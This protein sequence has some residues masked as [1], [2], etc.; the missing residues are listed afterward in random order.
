MDEEEENDPAR[1]DALSRFSLADLGSIPG[2]TECKYAVV[3]VV[4]G[5]E[6]FSVEMENPVFIF[7]NLFRNASQRM[8]VFTFLFELFTIFRRCS[9]YYILFLDSIY[10]LF[11][12][13]STLLISK[14]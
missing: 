1:C 4:D 14:S 2:I 6:K 3:S 7:N 12:H 13:T 5:T 8:H 10:I 11:K 9:V